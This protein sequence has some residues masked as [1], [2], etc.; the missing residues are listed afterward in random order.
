MALADHPDGNCILHRTR[1]LPPTAI[2]AAAENSLFAG[3]ED[4][5]ATLEAVRVHIG[6]SVPT[7]CRATSLCCTC[8][9]LAYHKL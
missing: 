1:L 6:V 3:L 2:R 5:L 9:T 8:T 4:D 7:Q